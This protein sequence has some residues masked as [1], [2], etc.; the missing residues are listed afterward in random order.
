MGAE[1]DKHSD[2]AFHASDVPRPYLSWVTLGSEW[3][4]VPGAVRG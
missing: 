1:I 2:S 4:K 3:T